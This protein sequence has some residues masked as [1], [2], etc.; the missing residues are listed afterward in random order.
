MSNGWDAAELMMA[1]ASA[2]QVGTATFADPAA[3]VKVQRELL[4]WCAV[5]GV[6]PADLTGVAHRGGLASLSKQ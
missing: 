2:V 6:G 1:G 3:P 5:R 4:E